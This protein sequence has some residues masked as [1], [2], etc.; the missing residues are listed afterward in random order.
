M[1]KKLYRGRGV[2]GGHQLP[3]LNPVMEGG[4]PTCPHPR[5]DPAWHGQI[6]LKT[7]ASRAGKG[8]FAGGQRF[9]YHNRHIIW[10]IFRDFEVW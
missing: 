9:A 4:V 8:G 2:E 1:P 5:L 6:A 7:R 10:A 3:T